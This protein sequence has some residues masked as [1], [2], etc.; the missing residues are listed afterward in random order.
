MHF[1]FFVA[2]LDYFQRK[3]RNMNMQM[4]YQ[5]DVRVY[6]R[7]GNVEKKQRRE[8]KKMTSPAALRNEYGYY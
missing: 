8:R 6:L 1:F 3:K 5:F 2:F 4:I 7:L